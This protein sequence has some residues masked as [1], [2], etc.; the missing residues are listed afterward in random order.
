MLIRVNFDPIATG[1]WAKSMG[2]VLFANT[3][4]R[5]RVGRV[6]L[7]GFERL[8]FEGGYYLRVGFTWLES[9]QTSTK[10]G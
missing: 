6:S 8:L 5:D 10:A 9:S 7:V 3:H 1:N 4:I 2:W